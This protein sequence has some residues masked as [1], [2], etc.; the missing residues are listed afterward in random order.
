MRDTLDGAAQRAYCYEVNLARLD[1][2]HQLAA[3]KGMTVP[4]VALAY[5]LSQPLSI[6]ALVGAAGTDEIAAT[7][8]AVALT[9][10]PD[11]LAWL[12]EG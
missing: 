4:Q 5:V 1:R 9:L 11:E 6:Y 10:S 7:T 8:A 3:E 12:E 2:A